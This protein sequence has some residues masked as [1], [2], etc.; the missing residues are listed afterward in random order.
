M[1]AN[2]PF[3]RKTSSIFGSVWRP[4]AIVSF[5]SRKINSFVDV[6]MIVDTGADYS[7]LPRYWSKNLGVDLESECSRHETIGVGG[8]E[9]VYLL[10]SIKVR[11]GKKELAVPVGFLDKDNLPPLLGRQNFMENLRVIFE[12]HITSFEES[13]NT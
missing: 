13:T 5:W 12:K 3:E 11:L 10:K 4:I 7:L 2:F 8:S 9:I 1:I 6:P